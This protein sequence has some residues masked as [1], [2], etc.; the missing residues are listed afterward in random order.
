MLAAQHQE[1]NSGKGRI[2]RAHAHCGKPVFIIL[3]LQAGGSVFA[4]KQRS[5]RRS[6]QGSGTLSGE[7]ALWQLCVNQE[8]HVTDMA[9]QGCM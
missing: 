7:G 4:C 8:L 3:T 1:I 9:G 2:E 6:A 5:V